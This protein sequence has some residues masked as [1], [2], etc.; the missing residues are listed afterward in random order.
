MSSVLG[1]YTESTNVS[2]FRADRLFCADT[3]LTFESN[4]ANRTD[5]LQHSEHLDHSVD[6]EHLLMRHMKQ[7]VRTFDK[8]CTPYHI[9]TRHITPHHS[10]PNYT[11]PHTTPHHTTPH[12]TTPHHTTPQAGQTPNFPALSPES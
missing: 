8:M 7:L 6:T 5:I 12:H 10:T 9:T 2:R 11:T 3:K 4:E 1:C